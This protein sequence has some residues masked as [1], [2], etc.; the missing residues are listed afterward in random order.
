MSRGNSHIS[1]HGV[2][3]ELLP[4]CVFSILQPKPKCQGQARLYSGDRQ[5]S[6]VDLGRG[7]S[8]GSL[9]TFSM[10][11]AFSDFSNGALESSLLPLLPVCH[12]QSPRDEI[13]S[14][15]P[16]LEKKSWKEEEKE[17]PVHG[18]FGRLPPFL[19]GLFIK[20]VLSVCCKSWICGFP[21]PWSQKGTERHFVVQ[22]HRFC[23]TLICTETLQ[24][25]H[26]VCGMALRMQKS[27]R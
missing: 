27:V 7:I 11:T 19:K 14:V 20:C 17:D 21:V 16:Q 18:S 8:P 23:D 10:T 5:S 1:A 6:A 25:P 26:S 12:H 3:E 4:L 15:N 13:M 22:V 9:C 2:Q 24:D